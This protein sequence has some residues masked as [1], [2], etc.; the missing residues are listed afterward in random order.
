MKYFVVYSKYDSTSN[1]VESLIDTAFNNVQAGL[2][3]SCIALDL[4]DLSANK[5][6]A[7][8]IKSWDFPGVL[9]ISEE[10]WRVVQNKFGPERCSDVSG[11][12]HILAPASKRS[13]IVVVKANLTS[14]T[15]NQ[16]SEYIKWLILEVDYYEHRKS[17]QD[18]E[19]AWNTSD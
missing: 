7:I 14:I 17:Q 3:H 11:C 10:V 4:A 15:L 16:L 19:W 5:L 2:D 18:L 6:D 8:A 13:P 12:R 1:S 9:V